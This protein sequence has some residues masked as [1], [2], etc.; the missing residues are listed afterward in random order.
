MKKELIILMDCGDTIID[1]ST[2]IRDKNE[3]V[4]S[5]KVIP[6]ADEVVQELANQ[7][8]RLA[9]VADGLAQSFKN[10]L[11]DHNIYDCFE[12]MIYSET[13]KV[14]KPDARMFKA[15]LGALDLSLDDRER[16]VMVGN[17][18][19]RDIR[20]AN[21]LGITSIFLDWS[22]RYTN[23][24]ENEQEKPDFTIHEPRQLLSLIEQLNEQVSQQQVID[25]K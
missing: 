24:P 21:E 11:T 2:E 18:L 7:G 3:V 1:E 20:G 16:V 4:T 15:A 6:H 10:M 8:Y 23:K 13:I 12:T 25:V 14:R 5:A 19:S 17:N 22:P 9:L